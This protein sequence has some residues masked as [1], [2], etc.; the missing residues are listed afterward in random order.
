[1]AQLH[2]YVP[3]DLAAKVKQKAK[4]AQMSVSK[5]L[6]YLI[7]KE[8]ETGWPD[9]YFDIFGTWEGPPLKRAKQGTV[10]ERMELF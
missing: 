5:Y 4:H 3:E 7:K 1:M 2:C 8:V 9:N 6:S 10:E